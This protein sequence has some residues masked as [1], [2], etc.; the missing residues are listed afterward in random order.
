M[1]ASFRLANSHGIEDILDL[2]LRK[3]AKRTGTGIFHQHML[4]TGKG[5]FARAI[6]IH[7]L[8]LSSE[9]C[10]LIGQERKTEHLAE[11][12]AHV[13]CVMQG[14]AKNNESELGKGSND[15]YTLKKSPRNRHTHNIP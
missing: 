9:I 6:G 3:G 11:Q 5:D 12:L 14:R 15:K 8:E 13:G 2:L 10:D 7:L 1:N 4:E